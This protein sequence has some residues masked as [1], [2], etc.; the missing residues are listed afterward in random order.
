VK[1]TAHVLLKNEEN[2]VWYAIMSVIDYVDNILIYDTGSTDKTINI[3][4]KINSKKIIFKKIK[5]EKFDEG[6]I[7]Q[8][9]L[10]E[11]DS[12]WILILDADEIW[13]NDSIKLVTNLIQKDGDRLDSIVVPTINMVGDMFHFQEKEAGRYNLAGR[14]GHYATRAINRR[15]P[16]LHGTGEHGVF[17]WADIT[18]TKIEDINSNNIKFI[19]APYVHATHLNRS[20]NDRDVLKRSMKLKYEIGIQTSLDFYYPEV[21]FR[22][23]PNIVKSPWQTPDLKYKL[24]AM[25]ETPLKKFR[26]RYL[27]KGVKHGY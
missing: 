16:N 11:T 10:D 20:D 22:D 24:I 6:I 7:R 23:R 19:D 21:F 13:W 17:M 15:I 9:M 8:Q 1:I 14:I 5:L 25:I 26:R 2:F 4:N 27:M 18:N 3:V 12:D